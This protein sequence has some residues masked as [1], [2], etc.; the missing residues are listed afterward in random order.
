MK[1]LFARVLAIGI[2]AVAS[3][4]R[5]SNSDSSNNRACYRRLWDELASHKERIE[6]VTS[7]VSDLQGIV[8]ELKQQ[9][10]YAGKWPTFNA[11]LIYFSYHLYPNACQ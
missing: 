4:H 2:L 10:D 9:V 5:S 7:A 1:C 8:L 11:I 6:R 3:T